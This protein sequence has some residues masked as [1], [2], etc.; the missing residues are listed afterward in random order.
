MLVASLSAARADAQQYKQIQPTLTEVEWR[1]TSAQTAEYSPP[2]CTFDGGEHQGFGEG[3]SPVLFSQDDAHYAREPRH[4]REDAGGSVYAVHWRGEVQAPRDK[5]IE[6]TMKAMG[7]ISAG[8]YHPA[9]R[10]NAAL[11]LGRLD[12]TPGTTGAGATPPKPLA[13]GTNALTALVERD[14][15]NGVPV[16]SSVK[17]AALVGLERHTRFGVDPQY[18]DRITAAALAIAQSRQAARRHFH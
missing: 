1:S 10:Y 3:I 4:A 14:D 13:T 6:L 11:V 12:Q 9:V 17:M 5:M 18:V 16:P 15:I 2:R 7:P 8:S